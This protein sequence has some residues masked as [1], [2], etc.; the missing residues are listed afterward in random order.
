MEPSRVCIVGRM[1]ARSATLCVDS[2]PETIAV[3]LERYGPVERVVIE[4]GRMTSQSRW[5]YAS[6]GAPSSAS[7]RERRTRA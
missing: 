3:A 7:M 4:T 6:W 5:A 2:K 1:G